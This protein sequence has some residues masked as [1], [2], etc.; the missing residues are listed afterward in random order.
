MQ[1]G[2]LASPA[3]QE[4]VIPNGKTASRYQSAVDRYDYAMLRIRG[5]ALAGTA[6]AQCEADLAQCAIRITREGLQPNTI[7][8]EGS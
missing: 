1:V 4:R 5:R 3:C 7:P 2:I 6:R 8:K